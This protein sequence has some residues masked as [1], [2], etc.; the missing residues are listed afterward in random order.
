MKTRA[1]VLRVMAPIFTGAMIIFNC[2]TPI[3]AQ[4]VWP[5]GA[6]PAMTVPQTPQAQRTELNNLRSQVSW[7]QNATR[8]ASS[9]ATGGIDAVWQ[10][11]QR[12]RASYGVFRMTLTPAQLAAGANEIAELDAGLD[13]LQEAFGNYQQ[14]V[15]QGRPAHPA[16]RDMCQVLGQAAGVWLQQLNRDCARLRVGW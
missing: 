7:L 1:L 13:I 9:Y 4:P 12:M 3:P 16:L 10:Q 8:T 2:S 6:P 11:F 14:D 15:A 5:Y